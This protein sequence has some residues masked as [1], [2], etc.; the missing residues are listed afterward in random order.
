MLLYSIFFIILILLVLFGIAVINAIRLK[1]DYVNGKPYDTEKDGINPEKHAKNLS[2]MIQIPSVSVR[3]NSDLTY[4]YKMHEKLEELYPLIHSKLEKTDIDGAL[5]YRWKGKNPDRLP[6]LLMSHHDVV[7]ATGE[8]KYPA[9]SGTIA[10]GKIWGRGA[11]DTKGALCAI[12]ESVEYLLSIGFTPSCDVYIASSC[13]EEITGDGAVKTVDYLYKKGIKFELVM[14]EGG[15]VMGDMLGSNAQTAM[16]GIFEK[17]RANIKFI[18]NSHG[19]HASI[20]FK[21]NPFARLAKLIDR[22][23]TRPP[24]KKK[25]TAPVKRMYKEMVPYMP[26]KYRL[27]LGNLWLFGWILPLV[28]SKM[29]GQANALVSTTCVFTQA[30]GSN[31]ANVIPEEASVTANMRFMIHEPL[32]PSLKK[33]LKIAQRYDIWMEMISGYDIPPVANMNTYAY[34]QVIKQIKDTFGDIPVIPYVMLAGTDA[35]HYTKICDC[36]LRFVPLT[37]SD[38]QM[39]S[40]HAV[41]ENL[42][43]ASLSRAVKFYVDFIRHYDNTQ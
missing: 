35:R 9:F 10:E 22:I 43:V 21:N 19:G 15:S 29:G 20:P 12:L 41:N 16:V 24:F 31:G 33:V 42:D 14:D 32:E 34:R 40:A 7:E 30:K 25:I 17:G 37:M 27:V 11:I 38:A 2:E 13:N 8:W 39:K 5:L 28:M 1:K 3:G 26:F 36:V 18:A 23:E 6:I 4:I